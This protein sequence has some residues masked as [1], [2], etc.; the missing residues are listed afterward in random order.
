MAIGFVFG[1]LCFIVNMNWGFFFGDGGIFV[2]SMDLGRRKLYTLAD[3][4]TLWIYA[5]RFPKKWLGF[6]SYRLLFDKVTPRKEAGGHEGCRRKSF[7]VLNP[8]QLIRKKLLFWLKKSKSNLVVDEKKDVWFRQNQKKNLY[9]FF[10]EQEWLYKS[11]KCVSQG[12][13]GQLVNVELFG[14]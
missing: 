14:M 11:S 3:L 7:H 6:Y 10:Q 9:F 5:P 8:S 1:L 12:L 4:V 2:C 13:R